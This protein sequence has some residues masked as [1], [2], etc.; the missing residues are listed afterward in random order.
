MDIEFLVA[1]LRA[2]MRIPKVSGHGGGEVKL[3]WTSP[4]FESILQCP[5]AC[6]AFA[7]PWLHPGLTITVIQVDAFLPLST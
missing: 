1:R 3:S 5:G 2:R 7:R 6:F 4:N